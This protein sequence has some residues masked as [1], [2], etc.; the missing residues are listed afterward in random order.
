MRGGAGSGA[1]F[2]QQHFF[3]VLSTKNLDP[4]RVGGGRLRCRRREQPVEADRR[5]PARVFGL[6]E[7][8][9][10]EGQAA[11]GAG[12]H[13]LV[14]L[15]GTHLK[16]YGRAGVLG[17]G[18]ILRRRIVD[19]LDASADGDEGIRAFSEKRAPRWQGR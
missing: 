7:G 6:A 11:P 9:Q 3:A 1:L 10:G 17:G 5:A 2:R 8:T 15:R 14:G 4:H 16:G 13:E 12:Q 19:A 18:V